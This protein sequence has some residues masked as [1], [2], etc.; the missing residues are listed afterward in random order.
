MTGDLGTAPGCSQS[1]EA[2]D[3]TRLVD[4]HLP[5]LYAYAYRLTGSV[6]EAEDLT[7]Q[8]FLVAQQKIGQ[9]RESIKVQAWLLRVLRNGF[10]KSRRKRVPVAA[11]QIEMDVSQLSEDFGAEL[12]WDTERLQRALDELP[13]DFRAV[14]LMFY[15][16]GLSYQ[17][18]ADQTDAP[19]GTVM[20]RLSRAKHH[21]REKMLR[22]QP[23]TT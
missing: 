5:V 22:K 16:E 6:D 2:W 20:S 3:M 19:I 7:Q 10:L 21:L 1:D 13:D 11:S 12:P 17:Q 15:F 8:T 23:Q 4:E 9:L 18:I 14:V